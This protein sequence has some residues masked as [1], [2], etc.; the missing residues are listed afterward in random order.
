MAEKQ[1][2]DVPGADTWLLVLGAG[3]SMGPPA[4]L[5]A[6]VPVRDAILRALGWFRVPGGYERP[7]P[8]GGQM[9]PPLTSHR[10][11]DRDAPAEVVF[12][13]LARFGV[14]F[15]QQLADV[16][17]SADR[18]N[19]VHLVAARVLA[20]GGTVWTPNVDRLVELACEQPPHCLVTSA[21]DDETG[22]DRGA[23]TT[24]DGTG[25][26]IKFHGDVNQ[27]DTLAFTDLQL[28]A[29]F[30]DRA[31]DLL[32]AHARGRNLVFYGYR[33]A[34]ADLRPVI[35]KAIEC[36]STVL[37][38]E[39][40]KTSQVRIRETFDNS[41][42]TI[43]PDLARSSGPEFAKTVEA[44]IEYAA[45]HGLVTSA[46]DALVEQLKLARADVPV[47]FWFPS[48]PAI[49]HARLV[50]R[51]GRGK[52]VR[53]SLAAAR[54]ADLLRLPPRMVGPHLSWW[55]GDWLRRSGSLGHTAI[56]QGGAHPRVIGWLP[57]RIRTYAVRKTCEALL[58][59]GRFEQLSQLA[60][61]SLSW[62]AESDQVGRGLD[63][64]YLGHALRNA[65]NFNEAV[66]AQRQ[67]QDALLVR[68]DADTERAAGVFLE[69]GVLALGQGR[70]T[71]ARRSAQDLVEAR[72]Q[73]AIGRWSG[74]GHW[75]FAM[76][77]LYEC[78][79]AKPESLYECEA[80]KTESLTGLVDQGLRELRSARLD[81]R[82]TGA[83]DAEEDVFIASLLAYRLRLALG[84]IEHANANPGQPLPGAPARPAVRGNRAR[85]DVLLL[86]ADCRIA[87]GHVD[88][89][90]ALIDQAMA[91]DASPLTASVGELARA[92]LSGNADKLT[93]TRDC[94][95]AAG[96]TWHAAVA[97]LC[98]PAAS[99]LPIDS[100]IPQ[101]E[102]V[103]CRPVLWLLS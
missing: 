25:W 79:V 54:R 34:D 16:L 65:A 61:A 82:D 93:A 99:R 11:L 36:A 31:V 50:E 39:P 78:G 81:F 98:L 42:V 40:D 45:R 48:V 46:D 97:D 57:R 12:G 100:G 67:A 94:A 68:A 28:C 80:A 20:T 55:A 33:G 35:E 52:D 70:I 88:V 17:S 8:L 73:Y 103:G 26:L 47:S 21:R 19:A 23:E 101:L 13:A 24:G 77:Y 83:A 22:V 102:K 69:T 27:P 60:K 86:E 5:P 90:G 2:A 91:G 6:F 7:A 15:A 92:A 14:P 89:A 59:M 3:A 58:P 74:W 76:S 72:G 64:Y 85:R 41:K 51:F 43:L 66:L 96:R 53:A 71:D 75:L 49:V 1:K 4:E 44:F 84:Q 30:P 18:Y 9:W 87:L 95:V 32:G 62:R 29:P 56:L 38:F 63:D 10:L 37:W